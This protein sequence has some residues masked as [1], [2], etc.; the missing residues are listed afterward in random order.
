[1]TVDTNRTYSPVQYYKLSTRNGYKD[2]AECALQNVIGDHSYPSV[3]E[4]GPGDGHLIE[5][6]TANTK[7]A[8]EISLEMLMAFSAKTTHLVHGDIACAQ[9]IVRISEIHPA[10]SLIVSHFVFMEMKFEQI[11]LAMKH[12][13]SL[14]APDGKFV[15]TITDPDIIANGI[16][17]NVKLDFPE[18]RENL[19]SDSPYTVLIA[20]D[21]G[22]YKDVGIH[23]F[24]N[25]IAV[26]KSALCDAGF[27]FTTKPI[28]KGPKKRIFAQ[29]FICSGAT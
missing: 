27:T 29:L 18:G 23:D 15:F 1:M 5:S 20:D 22:D 13:R 17:Q 28:K 4:I 2:C 3:L 21:T 11:R 12:V 14:M 24:F 16:F 7:V 10:F 8:I 26:Y 19:T 6:I 9:D 25:S